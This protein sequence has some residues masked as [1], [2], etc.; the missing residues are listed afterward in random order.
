MGFYNNGA[1]SQV[2]GEA[3]EVMS[4]YTL[5][6]PNAYKEAVIY[7]ALRHMP[8]RAIREF[9]NSDAAK[10]ML[11]AELISPDTLATL[12]FEGQDVNSDECK[13]I[14]VCHMAKENEDPEWNELVQLRM[15]ERELLSTLF[16]RYE[17]KADSLAESVQKDVLDKYIPAYIRADF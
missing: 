13:R 8:R 3:V 12:A 10:A 2:F 1:T 14:A 6:N 11:E 5:K 7:E 16:A 15:K 9:A 17:D 4:G